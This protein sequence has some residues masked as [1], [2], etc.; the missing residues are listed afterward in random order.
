MKRSSQGW[1]LLMFFALMASFF[2]SACSPKPKKLSDEQPAEESF[3]IQTLLGGVSDS[4]GLAKGLT[5]VHEWVLSDPAGMAFLE[6][7]ASATLYVTQNSTIGLGKTGPASHRGFTSFGFSRKDDSWLLNESNNPENLKF[8]GFGKNNKGIYASDWGTI[9]TAPISKVNENTAVDETAYPVEWNPELK[10]SRT[11]KQ[12]GKGNFTGVTTFTDNN[13]VKAIYFA[14]QSFANSFLY[15]YVFTDPENL[16]SGKLYVAS[17]KYNYWILLDVRTNTVISPKYKTQTAILE[18]LHAASE[19]AGA[20]TKQPISGLAID[21][22]NRQLVMALLP[23]EGKRS[24]FGGLFS[25]GEEEGR[26]DAVTFH[27]EPLYLGSPDTKFSHPGSFTFDAN[28]NTWI[29]NSLTDAD[30]QNASYSQFSKSGLILIPRRGAQTGLSFLVAVAE[31]N[32]LFS[33]IA[34]T[35]AN[36]SLFLG[37]LDSNNSGKILQLKGELLEKIGK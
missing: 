8:T 9:I 35:Q 15:K 7:E 14:D 17:F 16:D 25:L 12:L 1:I 3:E 2:L 26:S 6:N 4:L 19:M 20:T 11:L 21:P 32:G 13:G 30:R 18:N 24:L 22:V 27:L 33:G 36:K 37:Y 29:I 23:D 28:G 5:L 31:R 34:L 10:T